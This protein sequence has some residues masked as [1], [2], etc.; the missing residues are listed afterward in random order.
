MVQFFL[1]LCDIHVVQ[2]YDWHHSILL[3]F[4]S[5]FH[6]VHGILAWCSKL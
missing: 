4:D 3:L 1:V 6:S 5:A 2:N